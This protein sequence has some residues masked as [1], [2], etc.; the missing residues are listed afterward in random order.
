[1]TELEFYK[2][3]RQWEPEWRW[4]I[5]SATKK[6]DVI[7]WVSVYALESF[8]K[9]LPSTLFDEGGIECR[10]QDS[11]IAIWASDICYHCGIDIEKIFEK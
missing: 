8:L 2:W 11:S 3:V 6:D 10:L 5:N 4:D 9:L 1:M 7:I